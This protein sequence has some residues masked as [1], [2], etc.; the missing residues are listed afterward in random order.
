MGQPSVDH[1]IF[2]PLIGSP[3]EMVLF[4]LVII[5]TK[6]IHQDFSPQVGD[7]P[8]GCGCRECQPLWMGNHDIGCT[9]G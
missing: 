1:S 4:P 3:T 2:T 6:L 9:P 7:T 5:Q 8:A